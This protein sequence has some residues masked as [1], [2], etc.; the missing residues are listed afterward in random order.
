MGRKGVAVSARREPSPRAKRAAARRKTL[1]AYKTA[2]MSMDRFEGRRAQL[3]RM[4]KGDAGEKEEQHQ[5]NLLWSKL[6]ARDAPGLQAALQAGADVNA[7]GLGGTTPLHRAAYFG[8]EALL[9]V[10]LHAR[11][12]VNAATNSGETALAAAVSHAGPSAHRVLHML[13]AAGGVVQAPPPLGHRVRPRSAGAAGQCTY[14]YR[15]SGE[16]PLGS[17]SQLEFCT[18]PSR[19]GSARSTPAVTPGPERYTRHRKNSKNP[20]FLPPKN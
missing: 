17:A 15:F 5:T 1:E 19:P 7:R 16:D 6:L 3:A 10:L 8:D 11:A 9:A 14:A 20:P 18:R 4:T 2:G 12:D 13:E